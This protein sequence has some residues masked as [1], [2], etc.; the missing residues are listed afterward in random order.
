MFLK[1]TES[2]QEKC[3]A[4]YSLTPCF[5]WVLVLV[6]L[7]PPVPLTLPARG[8]FV[9]AV[10]GTGR[11]EA[12]GSASF[13]KAEILKAKILKGWHLFLLSPYF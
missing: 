3:L 7:C 13:L 8:P 6:H 12:T 1:H 5:P 11:Q 10:A 9:Q 2:Y 4:I